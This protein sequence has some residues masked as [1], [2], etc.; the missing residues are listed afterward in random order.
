MVREKFKPEPESEYKKITGGVVFDTS[1]HRKPAIEESSDLLEQYAEL[2]QI[3][4]NDLDTSLT[5]QSTV[6]YRVGEAYATAMSHRDYA[7]S[8]IDKVKADTDKYIRRRA[9][10]ENEKVTEAQVANRILDDLNYQQAV[11]EHLE[12]KTVS[13]KWSA[14]RDAFERRCYALRDLCTLWISGYYV[15]TVNRN[16]KVEARDRIASSARQT[17]A[18]ERVR[19]RTASN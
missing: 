15:D 18:E 11:I 14:L 5:E 9:L 3:D 2:L 6:Y 10:E 13:D 8:N 4:K 7:K 12:W 19:R 1:K 16:D 17:L